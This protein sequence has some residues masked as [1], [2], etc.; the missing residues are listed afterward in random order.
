MENSEWLIVNGKWCLL[1]SV[2]RFGICGIIKIG[3]KCWKG[4][5]DGNR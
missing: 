3:T 2:E 4:G 1:R 5:L